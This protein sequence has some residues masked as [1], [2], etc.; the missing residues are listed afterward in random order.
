MKKY[1]GS[2]QGDFE[3][4]WKIVNSLIE[5]QHTEIKASFQQ[6]LNVVEHSFRPQLFRELRGLVSRKAL[7]MILIESNRANDV[8]VDT[9]LCGCVIR[10]THG[11]SCAH[12]IAECLRDLRPI[13]I[14]SVNPHW[15]KLD[16]KISQVS[17]DSFE[18]N[19]DDEINTI[20]SRFYASNQVGKLAMKRKLRELGNPATTFLAPPLQKCKTKGRPSSK[21]IKSTR[22]EPS[23]FEIVESKCEAE[24]YEK[25]IR[26]KRQEKIPVRR[27]NRTMHHL[28]ALPFYIKPYVRSILDVKADG[29]CGFRAVANLLG[30]GE[31]SWLKVREDLIAELCEHRKYYVDFYGSTGLV[32]TLLESLSCTTIPA[33]Y[34]NWMTLPYM[35]HLI[36]SRYNV[37]LFMS[38]RCNLL[39]IFLFELVHHRHRNIR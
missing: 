19:I 20:W 15:L 23:Y 16:L 4:S 7:N 12:E 24:L 32:A 10:N 35:G 36:A 5:L 3:S 17:Y 22:R 21:D 18:V 13:S 26:V 37:V 9:T 11:L 29:H 27:S 34:K 30:F 8:G 31:D 39:H 25:T 1:L 38:L 28:D 6:S 33:P 2:S 14:S